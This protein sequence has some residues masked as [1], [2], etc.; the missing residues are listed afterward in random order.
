MEP[1]PVARD[2]PGATNCIESYTGAE[3]VKFEEQPL[4]TED[5]LPA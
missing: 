2:T 5:A 4:I 1:I 3:G